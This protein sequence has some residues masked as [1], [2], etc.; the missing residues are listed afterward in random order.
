MSGG[1]P[2]NRPSS[3]FS[4]TPV[5]TSQKQAFPTSHRSD[6]DVL[7]DDEDRF[8][9]LSPIYSGSSN[10]DEDLDPSDPRSSSAV[11]SSKSRVSPVRCCQ[12][13]LFSFTQP[14]SLVRTDFYRASGDFCYRCELPRSRSDQISS[15]NDE[16]ACSPTLSAWELWLVRKAKEDRLNMQKKAKEASN[17]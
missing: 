13:L 15:G 1:R 10:S 6:S 7:S 2:P 9:L 11:R 5:K 12:C 8:S 3:C 17:G 4:S 16:P 14:G